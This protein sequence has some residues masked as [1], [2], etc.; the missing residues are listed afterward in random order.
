MLIIM[1]KHAER[2]ALQIAEIKN[3]A[4]FRASMAAKD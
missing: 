3:S 4:A 2:H 1:A